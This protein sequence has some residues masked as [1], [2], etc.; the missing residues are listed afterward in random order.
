MHTHPYGDVI[1]VTSPPAT[2]KLPTSG[3]KYNV[4]CVLRLHGCHPLSCQLES[5]L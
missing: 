1:S 4:I 5:P 2:P 3:R